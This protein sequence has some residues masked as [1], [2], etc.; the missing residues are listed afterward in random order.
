MTVEKALMARRTRTPGWAADKNRL[1]FAS[2]LARKRSRFAFPN[3][4]VMAA[5]GLQGR[6]LNKHRKQTEAI[7]DEAARRP[8]GS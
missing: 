1:D 3:G 5:R 6:L 8:P 4:F 7:A 2:A